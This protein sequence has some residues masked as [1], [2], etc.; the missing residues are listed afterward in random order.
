MR[1]FLQRQS[2]AEAR[3]APLASPQHRDSIPGSR[4]A[5]PSVGGAAGRTDEAETTRPG[6]DFGRMPVLAEAAPVPMRGGRPLDPASRARMEAH[7][8]HDF[9]HVRVH[10]GAEAA[11]AASRWR[12]RAF[13][14]NHDIY[15]GAASEPSSPEHDDLLA[16]E[17]THVVQADA[18]L[19]DPTR[20]SSPVASLESE[21]HRAAE[22]F[23]TGEAA[24]PVRGAARGLTA[25][26]RQ[27]D[28]DDPGAPT[29]GNLLPRDAPHPGAPRLKLQ[30][31]G[32]KWYEILPGR[33]QSK[34][35]AAGWYDFVLQ[36]GEMWAEK[37]KGPYGHIEAAR[38]ERVAYAGQIRFTSHSGQIVEWNDG[39][40]HYQPSKV[41]AGN[42][43]LPLDK[44][45]PH[46]ERSQRVQLPVIQP[47]TTPRGGGG[48]AQPKPP[49]VTQGTP[50]PPA[51]T[52]QEP[53]APKATAPAVPAAPV[54]TPMTGSSGA[55]RPTSGTARELAAELS[56]NE[57]NARWMASTTRIVKYGLMA[58][59]ALSALETIAKA[60]QMSAATLAG[61]SPFYKE[62][63]AADAIE[64][65][66]KEVQAY[67]NSL[68]LV[69]NQMPAEGDPEWNSPYQLTQSQNMY[70]LIDYHLGEALT[71]V[72]EAKSNLDEQLDDLQEGLNDRIFAA[73]FLPM[74]SLVYA[75]LMLFADAAGKMLPSLRNARD[76]YVDARRSIE[77]QR[78]MAQAAM[79]RL[80]ARL[81]QLDAADTMDWRLRQMGARAEDARN[82]SDQMR[83]L[84]LK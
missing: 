80:E 74:T 42:A 9:G 13:T 64:A 82:I 46:P 35:R 14:L 15:F 58:W 1:T 7:F 61:G 75:D 29:F 47:N 2:R 77:F 18:A 60:I 6:H 16:H 12:A 45:K 23:R 48:T 53:A 11:G 32:G 50:T 36:D 55:G 69:V 68:N 51:V 40:G 59:S 4:R 44:F 83:A 49:A 30:Q 52:P 22:A 78:R 70:R 10:T 31:T 62:I 71:E 17:L 34:R 73:T 65:Q 26:L 24:P 76:S 81:R 79:K 41:F 19:S 37:S 38:G 33:E 39:S 43:G 28:D 56:R 66:A 27:G 25:P 63:K 67:Y 3:R 5:E 20:P 72:K 84:P 57:S 21:A 8:G 54:K